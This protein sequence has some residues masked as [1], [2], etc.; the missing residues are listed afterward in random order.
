MTNSKGMKDNKIALLLRKSSYFVEK[1]IIM[2]LVIMMA[3]VLILATIE[4]GN[5]IYTTLVKTKSL[6]IPLDDLMDLFG[7]FMLVLIGIELLDTIKVYL[8]EK[9]IHVEVVILVAIIAVARKVVILK[10]EELTGDVIIGIGVLLAALAITY[11]L[12]KR[13]GMLILNFK[14]DVLEDIKDDKDKNL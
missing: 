3:F 1:S 14:K 8:R 6:F 10:I 12:I 13:A 11:Y 5:F 9:V 7:V 2:A 4:L